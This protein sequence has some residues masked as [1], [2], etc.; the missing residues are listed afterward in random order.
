MMKWISAIRENGVEI[1]PMTFRV[2]VFKI[3]EH[4]HWPLADHDQ[5][6]SGNAALPLGAACSPEYSSEL[7]S[8]NSTEG[9]RRRWYPNLLT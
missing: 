6:P 5:V 9:S 1:E 8:N 7:P 3:C 4:N 2:F